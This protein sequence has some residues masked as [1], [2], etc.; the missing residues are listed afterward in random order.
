M[1]NRRDFFGITLGAGATLALTPELLRALQPSGR[2]LIQR[3]IPSS[4]EMLPVIGLSRGNDPP[5][6]AAF[7][8]VLRTF[9][10]NGGR[11]VDM[12]HGWAQAEEVVGTAAADLG[13]QDRIFWSTQVRRPPA[14]PPSP[15][16]PEPKVE[17]AVARAQIE[18]SF[19]RLKVSRIDLM[20]V[21]TFVDLPTYLAVMRE[22]RRE[23]RIRYIGVTGAFANQ[24]AAVE[25]VMRNE[26]IDFISVDYALDNR[27][28]EQ[29]LLPLAQER[30]IGVIA[31]FPFGGNSGPN[32]T[33]TSRLFRRVGDTPLPAWAAE[34]DATSWGQFFIKYVVSHPAVTVVRAGT[35]QPRHMLDNIH[36]GIGRL[37]NEATRKRMAEFVDALPALAGG[38][39]GPAPGSGGPPAP[40]IALSAAVLDRYVGEYQAPSGLTI[41]LRREGTTLF[42]KPGTMPEAPLTAQTETRLADPRG[43]VFEFQLDGQ[44][45][46]TG[47]ILEQ[48]NQRIPLERK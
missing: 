14:P 37:P 13:V 41:V 23:G 28:I 24:H 38:P 9:V 17:P 15:G 34:F 12:V 43:P 4:G 40:G 19:A 47:L 6:H 10:D 21:N 32:Q 48:G 7:K 44:G 3:A 36:G 20:L 18:T 46:V 25:S 8:D 11:A 22:M 39:Q 31:C 27:S 45:K 35:T 26:P 5:G 2:T 29:T 1:I 30:R 16:T 33:V 42:A